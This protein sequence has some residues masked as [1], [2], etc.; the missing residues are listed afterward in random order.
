MKP[1]T[2]IFFLS[3]IT[4]AAFSQPANY[5][6]A[7]IPDSLQKDADRVIREES[8]K[9]T[10]KDKNSAWY[11][12]HQVV[13][14]M[15][16][17]AKQELVFYFMA[18]KFHVL[19]GADI[20][21]YDAAG[22]KRNTYSRKEMT[23]LNY[24]EGL[25]PDGKL[26]YF[27]VTAPSYPIT[28]E[29]TYSI[30]F[31]GILSL[32]G[33]D[34]Q[35]PWESVQHA[36]FEVEAPADPGIRYKLVNT[37]LQP[38]K[39]VSGNKTILRWEVKNLKT[40]KLEKHSGPSY[41]Y[42]P[43]VL[44][45]PNQF[46]LDDYEGDMSSWK[47]F[48]NW[49]KDLYSKTTGLSEEKKQ[50]YRDMVKQA[51]TDTEK[52]RILYQ[53]MQNNMRYVS[54]QLG[55]GGWRPFPASFVDEKKY[56]DCKALSNYLKSAL[57]AVG[58]KSDLV[59][60]YRDYQ[61]NLITDDF[62]MN[63]FNHVILCIPGSKDSTWLECTSTTLPF[64]QLDESTKNRKA[65]LIGDGGGVLVNTPRSDYL[66][67]RQSS[68]TSIEVTPEGGAVVHTNIRFSG[69]D[70]DQL[71]EFHDYKDDEKRRAFLVNMSWKQPDVLRIA[72]SEKKADP[73][74]LKAE[75]EYE[76]IYSFNAGSKLFLEPRLYP[77]FHEEIPE[78]SMRQ[79]DYHFTYP[80]QVFDT[81]LYIFPTGFS[82]ENMPKN[83]SV[84]KPFAQ[85]NCTYN[86]DA[87][88]RTLTATA[89][90]QLKERVIKA[91]DYP[92]LY[93]FNKQVTTDMNEK[94]VIKKE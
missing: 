77:I 22:N 90:L 79:K 70:R 10:V 94:I 85:Y 15:N 49:I 52:A 66:L 62:P 31:K 80:Y 53:Y 84:S 4:C 68:R 25:V 16:E 45:A 23:S 72:T 46:Q 20:K 5:A 75:M 1:L 91:K 89:S 47:N 87:A 17:Q 44:I 59:I 7:A 18:D 56:G 93:D 83:R 64:A 86:W 81:T 88:N 60:I 35:S 6:V 32:P 30:K 24:G 37:N 39:N 92:E 33:Y 11:D 43:M 55:I 71:M 40:Y 63:N 13:T 29:Y 57:E 54:I 27:E 51:N 73:Y 12:V 76:K 8:I 19:D 61:P 21:V 74:W 9:V 28:V 26:T 14:V 50:F 65:M 42:K 58:V 67:N 41:A 3:L 38:E 36:V 2:W 82:M 34:L 48:G 78:Y 69:D